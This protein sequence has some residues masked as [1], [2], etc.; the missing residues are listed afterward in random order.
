MIAQV[1]V[2]TMVEST[3]EID[4]LQVYV[5]EC[6][7]ECVC[8]CVFG[9]LGL[10]EEKVQFNKSKPVQCL[11]DSMTTYPCLPRTMPVYTSY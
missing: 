5:H 8:V 11:I 6:V 7:C 3:F 10:R 4:S 9:C 2:A 1:H